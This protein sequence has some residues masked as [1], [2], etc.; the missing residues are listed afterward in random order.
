MNE[1][2]FNTFESGWQP[3]PCGCQIKRDAAGTVVAWSGCAECYEAVQRFVA[4]VVGPF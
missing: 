3:V 2:P 1:A 4:V